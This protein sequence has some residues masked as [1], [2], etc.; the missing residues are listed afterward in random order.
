MK[1]LAA[2][3]RLGVSFLCWGIVLESYSLHLVGKIG[4]GGPCGNAS[5]RKG[6]LRAGL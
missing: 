2:S 4:R 3:A 1:L 6:L 5:S